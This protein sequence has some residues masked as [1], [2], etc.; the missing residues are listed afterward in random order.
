[1]HILKKIG[2]VFLYILLGIIILLF[3]VG[4]FLDPIAKRVL[5]NQVAKADEGQY[6]LSLDAVD[7][8]VLGGNFRMHG[9]RFETDTVHSETPPVAFVTADEIAIEGVSWLTYLLD[10]RLQTDR[11]FFDNLNVAVYARVTQ[12]QED[13][14]QEEEQ[15]PF[16]LE[17]L[18]IY[19][20]IEDQVE[21]VHLRDLG[22]NDI[23]LTLVNVTSQDT[24]NFDARELNL[25]SDNILIDA[26]KLITDSR[27]FYATYINFEGHDVIIERTGN[28][29][30]QAETGFL[31][32]RT[33]EEMM[34][35]LVQEMQF[36][37]SG[38][39]EQDTMMYA[40][41]E[42][43]SLTNLD[44][45]RLQDERT[46]HIEQIRLNSL[47]FI[48]NNVAAPD[49]TAKA[50]TA[51]QNQQMNLAELSFGENMPEVMDRL[52]LDELDI[53]D[54]NARQGNMLRLENFDL[55]AHRIVVD[56][57]SAFAQNRFL[58]AGEM[59]SELGLLAV[60]MGEP[61][62][63]LTM[64]GFAMEVDQGVGNIGF[65][66]LQVV[67]EEKPDAEMWFEAD[68]GPLNVIG[69]DTRN[70]P[71]KEFSIDSIAIETPEIVAHMA[72]AENAETQQQEEFTAPDLYPAIAGVLDR[73]HLGK[74]ALIGADIT[75]SGMEAI[76]EEFHIPALYLQLRDVLI[77]EGTAYEGNRVLHTEDIAFR[78]EDLNY[79]LPESGYEVNLEYAR[80]STFEQFLE[81]G[82]VGYNYEDDAKKGAI[83]KEEQESMLMRVKNDHLRIDGLDFQQLVMNQAFFAGSVKAEGLDLYVYMDNNYPAEEETEKAAQEAAGPAAKKLPQEMLKNLEI[84][85]NLNNFSLRSGNI[86]YEQMLADADTAGQM[87]VTDFF[88][89]A[90][91]IT[92]QERVYRNKPEMILK[93]GG[94]IMDDGPFETEI[95]FDMLSNTNQT[96]ITGTVDSLDMTK[97]NEFTTYTSR[98]A[99]SSGQ[100]HTLNWDFEA[101]EEQ[102]SGKMEMSYEDLS[103]KISESTGSDTT[104]ILK[105]IGAFLANNLVLETDVPAEDPEE[106]EVV[107]VEVEKEDDMGF[108]DLYVQSLM[109]GLLEMMLTISFLL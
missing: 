58:H 85:L 109:D 2:K 92:N 34:H 73:F 43:F 39:Q 52:E 67:P 11:I 103:M 23:S 101:N 24:L 7:V 28:R 81:L 32:F 80:F 17:D 3:V 16:R 65:R 98:L 95:V 13:Q 66:E 6:S 54:V 36:M 60:S 74:F 41:L 77:A 10:D 48:N 14:E 79:H 90:E 82:K 51:Q 27:A 1:M 63:H 96:K 105:D 8:S 102:A 47:N 91:N 83:L 88:V 89:T 29:K 99:I 100:L 55:Q 53:I 42:N 44:M 97:L 19:P 5:E 18:D 56:E 15:K 93:A 84:P 50:D 106:P 46:G 94:K 30:L 35:I 4:L 86:V 9:M 26:N 62:M 37:E 71:Q 64:A 40:A 76:E 21:R 107:E 59:E 25:D 75:L 31:R 57:N 69:L 20:T 45:K 108:V 70:I 12:E 72:P 104:G 87:E 49:T 61:M 38:L 78:V 22:F 68:L 33:D